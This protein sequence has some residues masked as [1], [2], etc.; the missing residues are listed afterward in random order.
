MTAFAKEE[1]SAPFNMAMLRYMEIHK[2]QERKIDAMLE[3][4]FYLSYDCL[5]E[6]LSLC[7]FKFIESERKEIE[8]I[9]TAAKEKIT[10]GENQSNKDKNLT[11]AKNKLREADREISVF[12]HKYSMIFPRIEAAGGLKKL[13]K[14]YDLEKEKKK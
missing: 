2:V 3:N 6:L 4:N 13:Y 8:T 1:D 9:L 12:M 7:W 11:A 5:H 10:D 14:K